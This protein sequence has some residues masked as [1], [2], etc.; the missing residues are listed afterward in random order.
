M[1]VPLLRR[2]EQLGNLHIVTARS[3]GRRFGYLVSALGGAFHAEGQSEA[4][5]VWFFAD[6]SWPGLGLKLQRASIED[7]R[8]NGVARVM[9][10]NL[11]GSRVATLYRRLG[12][13]ETG[14]R[15]VLELQ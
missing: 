6:P 11:D 7:L 5:Q 13:K 8:A 4:D 10:L 9:M 2:V 1:N 14:Q 15:Y 12:A 3:N